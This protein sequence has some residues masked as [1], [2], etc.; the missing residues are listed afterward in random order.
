MA[1]LSMKK[2]LCAVGVGALIAVVFAFRVH[3]KNFVQN[4]S[5]PPLPAPKSAAEFQNIPSAALP[6]LPVPESVPASALQSAPKQNPKTSVA[7][8]PAEI[9]LDVPFASQAPFG[10]WD[11]PYQEACEEAAVIMAHYY[12]TGVSLTPEK[13][14]EEILKLV[15]WEK[16][17]FGFYEDTSGAETARMLTEYFGRT[18]VSVRYG[19]DVTIESIKRQVAAGHPVILLAAGRLLPN[20]NFKQPGPLYHALVVRGYT[21]NGLIITNDPGTHNGKNF[22]YA[23]D[24]LLN[25][26]HE[27][28]AANILDGKKVMIVV[29]GAA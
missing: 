17:T 26:I 16:K 6:P 15:D 8:L 4:L 3:L 9:N 28:N 22:L 24:A 29:G 25:A 14:N 12:F 19:A 13:M 11:M 10:N 21:K 20:P 1:R 5:R 23:P 18:K 2:L 7:T 27:W